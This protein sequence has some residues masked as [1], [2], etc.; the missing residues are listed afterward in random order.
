MKLDKTFW[1]SQY[2]NQRTGWDIGGISPQLQVYFEQIPNKSKKILIPGCGNGYEAI[3]LAQNGFLDVTVVDL[4]AIPLAHVQEQAPTVKTIQGDFFDLTDTYDLI[5]EQ[6]F[7][8]ALNPNLRKQ[9]VE[10]MANLLQP[11]GK[12]AGLLFNIDFEKVGPPFG[13]SIAEYQ[14]LFEGLFEIL[15]LAPS[16]LSIKPRLGSEAFFEF[17]KK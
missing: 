14:G 7:F 6:T 12:L 3:W 5:I 8:C 1:E 11:K 15:T 9:Y 10:K 13:G 4:A 16:L 17:Q 2:T